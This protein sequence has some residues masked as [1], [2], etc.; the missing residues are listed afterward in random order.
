MFARR[1]KSKRKCNDPGFF[2]VKL[3]K[4]SDMNIS[5]RYGWLLLSVLIIFGTSCSKNGTSHGSDSGCITRVIP[6]L[7]DTLLSL[8]ELDS[9][10][11]LFRQNNL[12]TANLQ[13]Y[14]FN[15]YMVHD[16]TYDG[17]QLQIIATQFYH[18]LPLFSV[19]GDKMFLFND[20]QVQPPP[21]N[22]W[23]GYDGPAPDAD[24]SG[25]QA[26]SVL[27]S[28][29][30]ERLAGY[31]NPGGPALWPD[32]PSHQ[33]NYHDSCLVA[34]LGYIDAAWAPGSTISP[35]TALI[36]VW[37]VSPLSGPSVYVQDNNGLSWPIALTFPKNGP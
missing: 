31:V 13:F 37:K 4:P 24:T 20:G 33:V 18:N 32:S 5:I 10:N 16:S 21:P 17:I 8:D 1:F 11:V 35:N 9:I 23:D 7:T 3:T 28:A 15:G 25:H 34:K 19:A 27:R 22:Y 12:S 14:S 26:L 30:F 29:F 6:M 36:K 2:V